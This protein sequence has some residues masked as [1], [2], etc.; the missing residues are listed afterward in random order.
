MAHV[1]VTAIAFD[2]HHPNHVLASAYDPNSLYAS[3][4]SGRTWRR[5]ANGVAAQPVYDL[6]FHPQQPTVALAAT[7]DGVY[8]GV[9][10]GRNPFRWTRAD[11][12]PPA[13]AAYTLAHDPEMGGLAGGDSPALFQSENGA[14][15]RALTA[16]P[17]GDAILSVAVARQ[18]GQPLLL[19]GTDGGGL[20]TSRDGGQSWRLVNEIGETFVAA[21]WVAPWNQ[22]LILARTRRGLFR[23]ND[24]GRSWQQSGA[25]LDARVDAL[26]A[27]PNERAL[28]LGMSS[29]A[30]LRSRDAGVTWQEWGALPRDGMFYALELSPTYPRTFWAGAQS[31]LYRSDDG[32]R[33]WQLAADNVGAHAI[34]ALAVTPAGTLYIGTEDGVFV[35]TDAG[36]HWRPR[37][38]GLPARAVLSL[39]IFPPN[40]QIL[41]ASTDGKGI[42]RSDDGGLSWR[43]AGWD[44]HII[45]QV[46]VD[47]VDAGRVY[48]R[49]AFERMYVSEDVTSGGGATWSP[50][51]E[52]QQTTTEV[53][54]FAISPHAA[55]DSERVLFAGA[56]VELYR[57]A[58]GAASWHAIGHE[59]AGESVFH[60]AVDPRDPAQVYA[61]ATKGLYGSDDGGDSWQPVGRELAQITVT[62]LAFHPTQ[63]N[64]L[65]VGTKYRGVYRSADR[66]ENGARTWQP[67]GPG[68]NTVSVNS[69]AVS[70]D[71]RWLYAAT[72]RGFWRA[73]AE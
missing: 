9:R 7:V 28:Y 36:Q 34:H 46:A 56:A 44:G 49:V 48:V 57:S 23:S 62:A 61:G 52:G 64:V 58:D 19:A 33:G 37:R 50:R 10:A 4:D 40:P 73:R 13:R 31:G 16:M 35:S 53:T 29:G 70:P 18:H 12:L 20:F 65:Y 60:L 71:G 68:P 67:V 39:S 25:Q 3:N 45:P 2:P 41:Y 63:R 14:A 55:P 59:L 8:R 22:T 1:P 51:W 32:G 21:L 26:A 43:P 30:V 11:A 72:E 38:D 15:W 27:T 5:A 69:L 6:S 42:Y 54:S 66:G 47:P 24:G 17:D